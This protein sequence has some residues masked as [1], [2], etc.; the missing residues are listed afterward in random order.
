MRSTISGS[1]RIKGFNNTAAGT[2]GNGVKLFGIITLEGGLGK[3]N[4]G[5][6][7]QQEM[8]VPFEFSEFNDKKIKFL[9]DK[10]T[11]GSTFMFDGKLGL[12]NLGHGLQMG[13]II[14]ELGYGM[15]AANNNNN[16][17]QNNNHNQNNNGMNQQGGGSF[18]G[19]FNQANNGGMA[20][21]QQT[22]QPNMSQMAPPT[23]GGFAQQQAQS[24]AGYQ[25]QASSQQQS[26]FPQ[27]GVN[28][29]AGAGFPQMNVNTPGVN[30]ASGNEKDEFPF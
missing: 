26:G 23:Q 19:N 10:F 3:N 17:S 7:E 2:N 29:Q 9:Q 30:Q 15:K 6:W 25:Q 18:G 13:I 20:A 22:Q 5:G 12:V 14:S 11:I 1:M 21:Q 16:F 27:Q 8:D 24:Q 28:Q 4:Q